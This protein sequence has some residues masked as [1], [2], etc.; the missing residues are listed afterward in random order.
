MATNTE[1]DEE[2]G[3]PQRVHDLRLFSYGYPI[4]PSLW[5]TMMTEAKNDIQ[6]THDHKQIATN[7]EMG[8]EAKVPRR[9]HDL[10]LLSYGYSL[11]VTMMTKAKNNELENIRENCRTYWERQD[12]DTDWPGYKPHLEGRIEGLDY[13]CRSDLRARLAQEPTGTHLNNIFRGLLI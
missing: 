9:V 11:W 7:T 13:L 4:S 1:T 12:T 5:A 3:V 10:R 8:E 6:R 2:A